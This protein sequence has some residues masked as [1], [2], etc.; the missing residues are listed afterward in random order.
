MSPNPDQQMTRA[1]ARQ[2]AAQ[3]H[4]PRPKLRG[5]VHAVAAPFAALLTIVLAMRTFGDAARLLS[6]LV[7][8]LSMTLLYTVSAIYH[9]VEWQG[10]MHK[11]LRTFDHANI[12]VFMAG[13]YTPLSVFLLA[14]R[15]R[16]LLLVVIWV[17]AAIAITNTSSTLKKSRWVRIVPY[18][19]MGLIG[20]YLL[21]QTV[22]ALAFTPVLLLLT[23]VLLYSVG[24][25]VYAA[26][27]PNPLPYVFGSVELFH[28]LTVV[29]GALIAAVIWWWVVPH[30]TC[31]PRTSCNCTVPIPHVRDSYLFHS[32]NGI[33]HG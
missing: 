24:G 20:V 17:G 16:L 32:T 19:G 9:R 3:G 28:A 5:W 30:A 31:A 12:F 26:Q 25:A 7:F 29:S 11:W 1:Q 21:V 18:L 27:K 13:V 10:R 2:A 33:V 15:T 23:A 22:Q 8:G 14:G 4:G 6:V